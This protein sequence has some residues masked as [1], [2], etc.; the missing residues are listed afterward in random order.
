MYTLRLE[1]LEQRT[2]LN[3]AHFSPSPEPRSNGNGNGNGHGYAWGIE[4]RTFGDS[5]EQDRGM[6]DASRSLSSLVNLQT[7]DEVQTIREVFALRPVMVEE[8][9]IVVE[10]P[11]AGSNANNGNSES[12]GQVPAPPTISKQVEKEAPAVATPAAVEPSTVRP[13]VAT[14]APTPTTTPFALVPTGATPG[15]AA[16]ILGSAAALTPIRALPAG[17]GFVVAGRAGGAGAPAFDINNA[18]PSGGVI[19]VSEDATAA[20]QPTAPAGPGLLAAIPT[21]DLVA[22]GRGLETFL[23][24]LEKA[25]SE[26]AGD[27]GSLRPWLVAVAAAAGACEIARRQLKR[28]A[29]STPITVPDSR[30]LPFAG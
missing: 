17:E 13:A 18:G 22:L 1:E 21:V 19:P 12:G 24:R 23:T 29:E 28:A 15:S 26:L 27:S 25:G 5:G 2:L 16:E 4:R 14:P 7:T 6:G 10:F 20:E 9:I 30:S 3:G 11:G 8:V